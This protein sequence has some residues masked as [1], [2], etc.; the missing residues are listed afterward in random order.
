MEGFD[1]ELAK[2]ANTIRERRCRTVYLQFPEG[3]TQTV[4]TVPDGGTV[5]AQGVSGLQETAHQD[6]VAPVAG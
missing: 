3:L 6:G 5:T 4:N 1:F 2:I